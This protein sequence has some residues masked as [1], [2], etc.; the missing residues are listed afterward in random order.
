[1]KLDKPVLTTSRLRACKPRQSITPFDRDHIRGFTASLITGAC[2]IPSS[3]HSQTSKPLNRS[4][5]EPTVAEPSA[6]MPRKPRVMLSQRSQVVD[7]QD[8]SSFKQA[9]SLTK[10][11]SLRVTRSLSQTTV[12]LL[13]EESLFDESN[14]SRD[15][16]LD[17]FKLSLSRIGIDTSDLVGKKVI[18]IFSHIDDLQGS[19]S[20]E[21]LSNFYDVSLT[22]MLNETRQYAFLP[23]ELLL[24]KYVNI[25]IANKAVRSQCWDNDDPLGTDMQR[26]LEIAKKNMVYNDESKRRRL[27]VKLAHGEELVRIIKVVQRRFFDKKGEGLHVDSIKAKDGVE[28]QTSVFSVLDTLRE[29]VR[30]K[31]EVVEII[32]KV[33]V[34]QDAHQFHMSD[35]IFGNWKNTELSMGAVSA[36]EVAVLTAL[37]KRFA[38]NS[39]MLNVGMFPELSR[40]VLPG[41][42]IPREQFNYWEKDMAVDGSFTVIDFIAWYSKHII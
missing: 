15:A 33:K 36:A 11:Q 5:T 4:P 29:L 22:N 13:H 12:G 41:V 14:G 21:E 8:D 38:G 24:A 16:Y 26:R 25:L 39:Q 9:S 23:S 1:M 6:E 40:M 28:I 37:F 31:D 17:Q 2:Y 34:I 20:L 7:P 27:S 42:D 3:T 19:M 30:F 35:P 10:S 18:D 32:K